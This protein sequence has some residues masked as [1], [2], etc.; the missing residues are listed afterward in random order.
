MMYKTPYSYL[1]C[2]NG[3]YYYNR[4]IPKDIR[5][6]YPSIRI[7]LSLRTRSKAAAIR[8]ATS[9][10]V[11]L[12]E[13]WSTVRVKCFAEK[14]LPTI[15]RTDSKLSG[16]KFST[17]TTQYLALK[18]VGKEKYFTTYTMRNSGYL[19][20]CLGDQDLMAIPS[21]NGGKFRDA[22][23]K[24]GLASSSIKRIFTSVRSIVSLAMSEHGLDM[25]NPFANVYFP[26]RNDT[27]RRLPISANHIKQVQQ[28]C[29]K[30]NDDKRHLLCLI[31]DT[32]LR[33]SEAVGLRIQD[34]HLNSPIPYL[35]IQENEV[36]RLKT[37]QSKRD[38]PLVGA[39]LWAATAIKETTDTYYA[40]PRY[41]KDGQCNANSAS[42]TLNKWLQSQ[43]NKDAVCHS[44]RHSLRD[45]LR[46]VQCPSDI[47]DAIGGWAATNIGQTYGAGYDLDVLHEWMRKITS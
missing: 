17:A 47:T 18:G 8:G 6:I 39:S 30:M 7:V 29:M 9:L 41:T 43:V 45:R 12:E 46:A 25:I 13:Y 35:S 24:R 3:T 42:A 1:L 22:L 44:F 21:S 27:K 10:T 26:E 40:F 2:R 34:I 5:H 15:N 31:S 23:V 4:R 33:L 11:K 37:K 32:G 38:I 16:I 20:A 36:R 14:M 19:I 28:S